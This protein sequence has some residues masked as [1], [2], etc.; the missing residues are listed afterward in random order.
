MILY[1]KID[2]HFIANNCS[3]SRQK[4]P[5]YF[6]QVSL[7]NFRLSVEFPVM[8]VVNDNAGN[9]SMHS[10]NTDPAVS[11]IL[12]DGEGTTTGLDFPWDIVNT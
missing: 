8:V 5:Q 2:S 7:H 10:Y 11:I 9:C 12:M 1:L 3:I 6:K 4:N